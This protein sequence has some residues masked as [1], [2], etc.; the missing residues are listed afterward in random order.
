MHNVNA[1]TITN[2]NVGTQINLILV[3]SFTLVFFV[4]LFGVLCSIVW[5]STAKYIEFVQHTTITMIIEN[6]I[7]KCFDF[8]KMCRANEPKWSEEIERVLFRR[9]LVK[10]HHT[11]FELW[12]KILNIHGNQIDYQGEMSEKSSLFS[13]WENSFNRIYPK[14]TQKPGNSKMQKKTFFGQSFSWR[15]EKV[16]INYKTNKHSEKRKNNSKFKN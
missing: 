2:G 6:R 5:I 4:A 11:L 14:I 3:K 9:D 13:V 8:I 15:I 10:M 7:E 1:P 16:I 12:H